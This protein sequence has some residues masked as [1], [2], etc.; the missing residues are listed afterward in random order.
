MNKKILYKPINLNLPEEWHQQINTLATEKD[1]SITELLIQII[2][3]YLLANS[4]EKSNLKSFG[5]DNLTEEFQELSDRLFVLENK[6]TDKQLEKLEARFVI[7]EKLMDAIQ[8]QI[9]VRDYAGKIPAH[10]MA[11]A[12]DFDDEPDEILTDFLD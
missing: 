4:P 3:N 6:D 5:L 11:D 7:M 1:K 12:H 2:G 9:T 8:R 10:S